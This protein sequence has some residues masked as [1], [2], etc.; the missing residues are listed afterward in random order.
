MKNLAL[1]LLASMVSIG[2]FAND[3]FDNGMRQDTSRTS[4]TGRKSAQK[5]GRWIKN[6]S[7]KKSSSGN[8]TYRTGSSGTGSSGNG[9][10]GTGSSG[11]RTSGIGKGKGSRTKGS[12]SGTGSGSETRGATG[13]GNSMGTGTTGNGTGTGTNN[14]NNTGTGNGGI[15]NSEARRNSPGMNQDTIN[16]S[17]TDGNTERIDGDMDDQKMG[18]RNDN[19]NVMS[20]DGIMM[21]DGKLMITKNGTTMPMEIEMTLENGTKV[22]TDGTYTEKNGTTLRMKNGDH[23]MM[24]GKIMSMK[25]PKMD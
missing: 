15:G 12:G 8:G 17:R 2:S 18:K 4:K 20:S 11:G 22:M 13:L 5:E 1:V 24:S 9:T 25:K 7:R 16:K 19:M 10:Y 3:D 23:M 21:K 14:G 6:S